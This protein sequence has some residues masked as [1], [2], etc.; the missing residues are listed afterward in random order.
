MG[1]G[2][3]DGTNY[4][5]MGEWM[6]NIHSSDASGMPLGASQEPAG[7]LK[8]PGGTETPDKGDLLESNYLKALTGVEN[9]KPALDIIK[10]WAGE[11][12]ENFK[13]VLSTPGDAWAGGLDPMSTQGRERALGLAGLMVMGPAPIAGKA[14]EGTLGSFI[15]VK[16]AKNLNVHNERGL[17][18]ILESK[19]DHSPEEILQKTGWFRGADDKWRYEIDDST[20]K[21]NNKWYEET[22]AVESKPLSNEPYAQVPFNPNEGKVVAKLGDVLDHPDLYKA[23]PSIKDL[24]LVYDNDM[25]PGA[26]GYFDKANNAI[27]LSESVAGSKGVVLHEVQH[28]IQEEENFA[29]GGMALEAGKGYN[30]R[31]QKDAE[32]HFPEM[33]KAYNNISKKIEKGQELT[34]KE[35]EQLNFYGKLS[36]LYTRYIKAA[37][38]KA[39]DLYTRLAGETEARNTDTRLLLSKENRRDIPPWETE[40]VGRSSQIVTPKP[41]TTTAYGVWDPNERFYRDYPKPE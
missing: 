38:D 7:A 16:G 24:N 40:D 23:Y 9:P 26:L 21:F 39:S 4:A 3:S 18:Q 14:A 29:K 10:Q 12:F 11:K 27:V 33:A 28:M 6:A 5:D 30:L 2:L 36:Q 32:A 22:P 25:P 8:Q 31:F 35:R 1:V 37:N 17:A 13:N 41:A 19:G 15:G 34:E 20:S